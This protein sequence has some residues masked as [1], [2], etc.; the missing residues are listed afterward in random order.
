M[1]LFDLRSDGSW[2]QQQLARYT[3]RPGWTMRIDQGNLGDKYSV[4][5][6]I[7]FTTT[8]TYDHTRQIA[9]RSAHLVP[10]FVG[11]RRDEQAFARWLQ[12]CLFD[13]EMHESREW[14]RRDGQIYDNPHKDR[15]VL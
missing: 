6:T 2:V 12:T 15:V 8:D 4:V 3:Y 13:A 14:L 1:P 9:V 11:D 10:P 7:S 5:L